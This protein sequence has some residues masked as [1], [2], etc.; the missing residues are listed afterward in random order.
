MVIGVRVFIDQIQEKRLVT[1]IYKKV[2]MRIIAYA[3]DERIVDADFIGT[4]FVDK[5]QNINFRQQ[6]STGYVISLAPNRG[7]YFSFL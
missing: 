1:V 2:G 7:D 6:L 4:R 3:I 5:H